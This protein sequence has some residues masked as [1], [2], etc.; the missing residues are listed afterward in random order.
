MRSLFK[1]LLWGI[2]FL[3]VTLS[4][5]S[6]SDYLKDATI[7]MNE[8]SEAISNTKY[9]VEF[10]RFVADYNEFMTSMPKS[11]QEM[12]EEQLATL[13]G[14]QEYLEAMDNFNQVYMAK[15]RFFAFADVT[16]PE[17]QNESVVTPEQESNAIMD[18]ILDRLYDE[19]NN[20]DYILTPGVTYITMS[21]G[22][23]TDVLGGKV[24]LS[25]EFTIYKD[26]TV[27]GNL[28]ETN[29][30]DSYGNNNSY[31]HPLEGTWAETSKHDKRFLKID[32]VLESEDY[33][34][35]FTYYID[36]DL[37]AYANDLNTRPVKLR[38]K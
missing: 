28:I 33:Y 3:S 38:E 23:G 27:T 30:K 20:D 18:E 24:S 16:E 19:S 11:I 14:G 34:N 4:C 6:N 2:L 36:E 10:N 35:E 1:P 32:L 8:L 7:K 5:K 31:E 12:P 29:A 21:S 13:D 37:N 26:G 25:M 17:Y 9:E 15:S 22:T